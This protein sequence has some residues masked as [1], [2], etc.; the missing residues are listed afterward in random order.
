MHVIP[1]FAFATL[2]SAPEPKASS[3]CHPSS[4]T[5]HILDF[6]SET[7]KRNSTKLDRKQDLNVLYQVFVFEPI[8]KNKMATLASDWLRHFRLLLRNR[9]TEFNE[10][11]QEARSQCL[12]QVCVFSG[13]LV[14]EI[15][16]PGQSIKKVAH[17]TQVHVMWPF[18][19]L[20]KHILCWQTCFSCRFLHQHFS[21]D[22]L[23][24]SA[25]YQW[26]TYTQWIWG[27]GPT[28]LWEIL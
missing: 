27:Q 6:L 25:G 5:F 7:A 3:V 4:L 15:G 9:W 2:F 16:R 13:R 22:S 23:C 12:Y 10:N 11:W 28:T 19:P 26:K 17:C 14:Y 8:G 1:Y 18:G 20:V 24:R 21:N